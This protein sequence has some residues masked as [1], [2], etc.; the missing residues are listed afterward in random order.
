MINLCLG[1]FVGVIVVVDRICAYCCNVVLC[2][3]DMTLLK[4]IVKLVGYMV[5]FIEIKDNMSDS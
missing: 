1:K 4:E 2:W 3:G 5:F